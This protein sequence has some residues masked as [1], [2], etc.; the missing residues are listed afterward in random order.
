MQAVGM[1][2]A[3][4]RLADP[5]HLAL[6]C[7]SHSGEPE[8]IAGVR[9]ILRDGGLTEDDLGCPTDLPIGEVARRDWL[10][11]GR[12]AERVAM[13]CSGKHA[14]M[15]R[16][17]QAAGWPLEDYRSPDH[18]L[19][20]QLR[21]AVEEL[22]GEPAAAVGVDGCGAPVFA[23]SLTALAGAFLRIVETERTVADAMRA[24]PHLVGGSGPERD[25]TRLM[26]SVPGLLPKWGAEGVLAIAVPGTGAVALKIDDGAKRPIAPVAVAVSRWLGLDTDL[27][28]PDVLGGGLSVGTI[29]AV[30]AESR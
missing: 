10:R 26:R 28:A 7:A 19:Q 4:L 25:D 24:Y 8:H 30:W 27:E 1:L 15:L 29:R 21:T 16:T 22:C 12:S 23:M 20:K 5:A 2:R 3:G 14:G 6:V 13:N 17:C 18:P 9:A 11:A